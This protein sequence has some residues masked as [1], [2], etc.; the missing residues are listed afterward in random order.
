[1][2]LLDIKTLSVDFVN[3]SQRTQAVKGVSFSI[4]K[5]ETLAVVGES[6]SGKTVT[7]LSLLGLVSGAETSGQAVFRGVQD[8]V[9]SAATTDL[10]ALS[11]RD[12]RAVRGRDIA[13][14]FQEPMTALNPLF[15]VGNQIAEVL[16]LKEVLSPAEA[17]Q[18]AVALLAETG[19]PEAER[20]VLGRRV[21]IVVFPTVGE[22]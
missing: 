3:G 6:G 9:Q 4:N 13:M 15:S 16:Q 10:L 17:H 5:G 8:K 2:A 12:L 21:D 11:E 7:A 22:F 18:A 1:M 20:R 19:I 14:I